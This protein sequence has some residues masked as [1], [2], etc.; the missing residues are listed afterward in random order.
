M[1]DLR[2]FGR[3]RR[4]LSFQHFQY[5][6]SDI[7]E[8]T[9]SRDTYYTK[10]WNSFQVSASIVGEPT[11]RDVSEPMSLEKFLA[12]QDSPPEKWAEVGET[13]RE[14]TVGFRESVGRRT[15]NHAELKIPPERVGGED[16]EKR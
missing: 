1:K 15:K 12:D 8:N 6:I 11:A 4:K 16:R 14:E 10:W 9:E 7:R 5:S 2:R 13:R 3:V